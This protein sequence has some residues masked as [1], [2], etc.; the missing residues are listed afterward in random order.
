MPR[1]LKSARAQPGSNSPA[2]APRK[3]APPSPQFTQSQQSSSPGGPDRAENPSQETGPDSAER[4]SPNELSAEKLSLDATEP[5]PPGLFRVPVPNAV[6]S[7]M[8]EVSDSALRCL[9][10]LVHLSFRFDPAEGEWTSAEDWLS[11]SDIEAASGLSGQGTRNGLSE[12]ESIGWARADRSGRSYHYQLAMSVPTARFT[13]VPTA[14]LDRLPALDTGAGLRVVLAVLR[15]T[16]GW[17]SKEMDPQSGTLQV[18]HDRWTELSSQ[19][20]AKMTGRSK[21]AVTRAAKALQGT[22]IGRVRPGNGACKYRFLPEAVGDASSSSS[23]GSSSENSRDSDSFCRGDANDLTPDRQNSDPPS[24]S[25]EN[26]SRDKH[27]QASN[28]SKPKQRV[29]PS[30]GETCAVPTEKSQKAGR[31]AA[32]DNGQ[33]DSGQHKRQTSGRGSPSADFGDLP[34]EKRDL[35]QK[36]ANVGVWAGRIADLISRFSCSRIRANFQLY[37]RRAAEQTIRKPGAW[38][39]KAITEGYALQPS[40]EDGPG[41]PS[42]ES[43]LPSLEHKET[44]SRAEKEEYTAQGIPKDRFHRCLSGPSGGNGPQYMYFDPEIGEPADRR[45]NS[46]KPIGQRSTEPG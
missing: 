6:F 46:Q 31:R 26:S 28:K 21:T 2:E 13:Q 3:A 34:P 36:L 20:L 29:E 44:V 1:P 40:G 9:L 42:K 8:P 39:Y 45:P 23:T 30:S 5:F 35:A 4:L 17:T 10:A 18:V 14:L 22:W 25:K 33:S 12:L 32:S 41:G 19:A 27:G 11:R 24:F 16:W 15:G 38:L 7:K 37:R 43:S